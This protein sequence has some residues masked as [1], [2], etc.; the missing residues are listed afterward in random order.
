M[1]NKK[2]DKG[3]SLKLWREVLESAEDPKVV[4]VATN[5]VHDLTID[6]DLLKIS[7]AIAAY[8]QRHG[9]SPARLDVLV[10]TGDLETLPTDPDGK[11]YGYDP[12]TGAVTPEAGFRL[13]RN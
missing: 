2:G 1:Y 5:H 6:V 10:E 12:G 4:A 3:S 9:G 11:S 8:R 13:R 7:Q